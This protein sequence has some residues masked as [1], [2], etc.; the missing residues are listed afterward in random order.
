MA[1]L[2][3]K[4]DENGQRVHECSLPWVLI[5]SISKGGI[6][7][8]DECGKAWRYGGADAG[9]TRVPQQDAKPEGGK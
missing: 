6:W 9:W 8:C 7:R 1:W 4:Y 2:E 5:P 3:G